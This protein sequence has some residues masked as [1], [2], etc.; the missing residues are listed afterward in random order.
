MHI[1][2]TATPPN[3]IAA[4]MCQHASAFRNFNVDQVT[5]MTDKTNLSFETLLKILQHV[6]NPSFIPADKVQ[7][8][9]KDTGLSVDALLPMLINVAK[10]YAKPQFSGYHVGV[11]ALG[12]SGNIYLGWNIEV[13]NLMFTVHGEQTAVV[14]A[15]K[16]GETI[17]DKMAISAAPC[18][19]CRQFLNELGADGSTLEILTP[20]KAPAKIAT[21]LPEPFG[22]QD[23][24]QKG[25]LL[26]TRVA[27][28]A[29]DFDP[30]QEK[31]IEAAQISYHYV[32][33]N[34]EKA[35]PS[36]VAIQTK[37]GQIYT[38]SLLENAAYNPTIPAIMAALVDLVANKV[39]YREIESVW[40]AQKHNPWVNSQPVTELILKD[41]APSVTLQVVHLPA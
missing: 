22:P 2:S 38:G 14:N 18:G 19:H 36:G 33:E 11:A 16:H 31:A 28:L 6:P 10:T 4:K 29:G 27:M 30:L 9:L 1:H 3:H 35:S 34:A 40:L 21:L 12:K 23:L 26:S 20:N 13:A 41:I 37:D 5:K 17:I 32:P 8:I 7:M 25:A 24:D 15:R 39:P